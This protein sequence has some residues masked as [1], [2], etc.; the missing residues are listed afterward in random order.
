MKTR[1]IPLI[2]LS[3]FP[4]L[5]HALGL[6]PITTQSYLGE[7]LSARI[8]ILSATVPEQDSLIVVLGDEAA[9]QRAGLT[10]TRDLKNLQLKIVASETGESYIQISSKDPLREPV[11]SFVVEARWIGGQM[12]RTYT[13]LLD[14]PYY[15]AAERRKAVVREEPWPAPKVPAQIVTEEPPMISP[16]IPAVTT[17]TAQVVSTSGPREWT[18]GTGDTLWSIANSMRPGA[19]IS[20]DQIMLAILQANPDAFINGNINT[21]KHG[22]T[23]RSPS[24][25][26]IQ[27]LDK[28]EAN[29]QVRKQY[30]DWKQAQVAATDTGVTAV[31]DQPGL[32]ILTPESSTPSMPSDTGGAAPGEQNI[33]SLKK[34]LALTAESVESYRTENAE[35][36][37]R[38]S[39]AEARI[40]DLKKELQIGLQISA[41][42]TVP[43]QEETKTEQYGPVTSGETLWIIANRLRPDMSVSVNQMML[44]L[45]R[46]SPE[47]FIDGN[48]NRL[49]SGVVLHIPASQEILSISKEEAVAEVQSHYILWKSKR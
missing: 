19:D 2:F 13:V 11:L 32:R 41:P 18:V 43:A 17:P 46:A 9:F 14:P 6:G 30:D 38:L 40:E 7:P 45:L 27:A 28:Q 48:I 26:E 29:N 15:A 22:A 36:E 42:V 1:G 12:A 20:T 21:I 10:R 8:G 25:D 5:V 49:K 24:I 35:L 44:A 31:T 23:L 16:E 47:A 34:E 33:N 3:L 39:A 4:G 37:A